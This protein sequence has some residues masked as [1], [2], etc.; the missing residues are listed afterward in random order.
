MKLLRVKRDKTKQLIF[1]VLIYSNQ[2]LRMILINEISLLKIKTC[3]WKVICDSKIWE[4]K[5]DIKL[6]S[7]IPINV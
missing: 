4:I 1:K 3:L 7:N 6:F 5:I 2:Y